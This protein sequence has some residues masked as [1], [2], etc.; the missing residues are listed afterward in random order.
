M[1]RSQPYI[2]LPYL[3]EKSGSSVDVKV[4]VKNVMEQNGTE[5]NGMEQ[6]GPGS[7]FY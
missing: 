1:I 2:T 4:D 7:V 3:S 6:R 5:W